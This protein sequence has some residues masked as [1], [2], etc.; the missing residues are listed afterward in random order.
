MKARY[1]FFIRA[2]E[3]AYITLQEPRQLFLQRVN[4]TSDDSQEVFEAAVCTDCGRIAIVGKENEKGCFVQVARKTDQSPDDCDYFLLW[5]TDASGQLI[6]QDDEDEE[7]INENDYA[8]CPHCGSLQ[9]GAHSLLRTCPGC[10]APVSKLVALKRVYRTKETHTARCPACG[11]G[12][13]RTFQL[14][15]DAVTSV[16]GT[17]LYEL[18]PNETITAPKAIEQTENKPSRF[19]RR[20]APQPVLTEKPRQFLCFSDSRGE[21]AYFA[22]YMERSY[23]EFLRRRG[24]WQITRTM[25][26]NGETSLDVTAFVDRLTR[27]FESE[28]TFD[29][30]IPDH[31]EQ[32]TNASASK[33]NAWIAVLNELVNARRS[34]SLVS[35]GLLCY[36]FKENDKSSDAF[37]GDGLSL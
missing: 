5:N 21:A 25:R 16:L 3:G 33:R 20:A 11:H 15:N 24:I 22:S 37:T 13:F 6:G 9:A 29:T 17:S 30:W 10:G 4:R 35:L 18:M 1:H 8:V 7:E 2:L 14:G 28:R 27:L 19:G 36:E 32:R 12:E 26:S 23:E 31:E 34:T